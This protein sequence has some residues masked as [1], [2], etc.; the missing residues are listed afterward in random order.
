MSAVLEKVLLQRLKTA[1]QSNIFVFILLILTL[2]YIIF[3]TIVINH[4]SIYSPNETSFIGYVI[5]YKIDGNYLSAIIKAKE[6]LKVSYYFKEKE[7][8]DYFLENLKYGSTLIIEGNLTTPRQNTIPNTFNY[9]KYLYNQKIYYILNADEIIISNNQNNFYK[10]KNY[11]VNL[12]NHRDNNDYLNTLILG[13][14]NNLD[15]DTY[16][17]FQSNGISH[18]FAISG[19]HINLFAAMILFVLRKLKITEKNRYLFLIIFLGIYGG[20]ASF[21]ASLLRAYIFFVLIT[22][23]KLLS[24]KIN[25]IKILIYTFIIITSINPFYI[26]DIGFQYSFITT[27]GLILYSSYISKGNYFSRLIKISLIALLFSTPITL[28][29]FYEVNLLSIFA[30]LLIVPLVSFFIYPLSLISLIIPIIEPINT[31]F[32]SFLE[33]INNL[34]SNIIILKIII[35]FTNILYLILYYAFL[36]MF[37]IFHNIKYLLGL[38]I[39]L[40]TVKIAPIIDNSYYLYFIDV[41]QGDSILIVTPHQKEAILIDTGGKIPYSEEKW[42]VR[43]NNYHI[44]DNIITFLKSIN[45]NKIDILILSHGDYDHMGE[46]INLVN[47]FKVDKVIFNCGEFN[48]LEQDL[49]KVLDKKKIP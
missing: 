40:I 21:P 33:Y 39:F 7:E 15:A 10:L 45:I 49:I 22:F 43:N 6:K 35:P 28:Y 20:L 17:N 34:L 31:I 42:M 1:L 4:K 26:Y 29:N 41:G 11:L 24:L 37:T 3:S 12:I 13:I 9:E 30:N 23:N 16:A 46:A 8:K 32:I 5:S 27:L 2:I 48:E 14:K 36:L 47:N 19:M 38:I 25:T 18:L 44:S